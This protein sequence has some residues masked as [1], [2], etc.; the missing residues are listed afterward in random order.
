[1]LSSGAGNQGERMA[2]PPG[3]MVPGLGDSEGPRAG[4]WSRRRHLL[5]R[6]GLDRAGAAYG[7]LLALAAVDSVGYSVIGPV[8][9][10]LAH[11]TH[12]SPLVAGAVVA[13]F[14]FGMLFGFVAA[15]SSVRRFGTRPTLLGALLVV[16]GGTVAFIGSDSTAGYLAARAAMGLGS[17]GLWLGITFSTLERWPGQEYRCMSRIYAAYSAGALVGPALGALGGVRTPFVAYLIL[18]VAVSVPAALM[19][20]SPTPREFSADRAELRRPGFWVAAVAIMLAILGTGLVDGAL[21]L[22]L[23]VHLSQ[24]AI[25]GTFAALGIVV[26]LSSA[27][28]GH[29]KPALASAIGAVLLVGGIELVGAT[30]VVATW[31]PA[32]VA[33]GVGIGISQT[34]ATGLLLAAVPTERI[35]SAMVVWSQMGM[36][37]YLVGPLAGGGLGET[38]GYRALGI[39]P[40][41]LAGL[42]AAAALVARRRG[43]EP[44][45]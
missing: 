15:G 39:A 4:M 18:V 13:G 38:L 19:P 8:L 1:M 21:P 32:L 30:D 33:I 6:G 10:T 29:V 24:A 25:G 11:A 37:G 14:P 9:P 35:V 40:G 23:S 27:A 7:I 2:V 31:L 20:T 43:I 17:G 42:L 45:R 36:V 16:T 28:A 44:S 22:H 12:A 3:A 5:L 41:A 26:A 34:G